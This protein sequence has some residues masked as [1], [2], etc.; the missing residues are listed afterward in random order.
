[1]NADRRHHGEGEH[2]KRHVTTPT[3]PGARLVVIEAEFVLR[4]FETVFD[5]LAM[6]FDFRQSFDGR[7]PRS[8][9]REEGEVA[10]DDFA[11][12]QKTARLFLTGERLVVVA[13]IEIGEFEIGPVVKPLAFGSR[14]RKSRQ[15]S[16]LESCRNPDRPARRRRDAQSSRGFE[17]A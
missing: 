13:A 16:P 5:R 1:V 14:A 17:N 12:D 10:V 11:P 4:R 6:S 3:M 15:S 9:C 7:S 2:D 8:P